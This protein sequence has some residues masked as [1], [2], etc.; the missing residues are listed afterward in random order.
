MFVRIVVGTD[1]CSA[2]GKLA[3]GRWTDGF[4]CRCSGM[5]KLETVDEIAASTSLIITN[6]LL[7]AVAYLQL[8]FRKSSLVRIY[9]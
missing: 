9:F 6:S 2:T 3:L 8:E 7:N 4:F 5:W 1:R